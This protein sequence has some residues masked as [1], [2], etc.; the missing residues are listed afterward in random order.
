MTP[1]PN[2]L[3]YFVLAAFA[4][5]AVYAVTRTAKASKCPPATPE[6]LE[7]FHREQEVAL[8]AFPTATE[9]P[10]AVIESG[11]R[12]RF[13]QSSDTRSLEVPVVVVISGDQFWRYDIAPS[14]VDVI[15]RHAP[16]DREAFCAM[17]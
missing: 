8:V 7:R 1:R 13:P 10:E 6:R 12:I 14:G 9:P 15:A 16:D 5:A 17:G 4:G 3:G 11:R 2:A